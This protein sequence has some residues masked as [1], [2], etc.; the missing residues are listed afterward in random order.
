M[1]KTH[2]KRGFVNGRLWLSAGLCSAAIALAISAL[3]PAS[4][5]EAKG[6][7]ANKQQ[8]ITFVRS[9]HHDVSAPLSEMAKWTGVKDKDEYEG[10]LNPKLPVHHIDKKDT[11]VQS[12]FWLKTLAPTIPSTILNFDGI[13]YPGVGCNCLPPDTN[14][15]IGATQ[16]VQMVNEGFQV[17]NKSTGASQL[18]PN[19]ISSLWAGFGG[20]CQNGGSGDPVVLYDHLA[21]RWVITQFATATGGTPIT[22]ECLAVST[23]SDATGTYTRYGFHLGPNFYD[24]PHLSVWPDAY[25]MSMN[26]FN[27]SGTAF[28]G[29][30]AFAFDRAAMVAGTASSFVTPGI[31]GGASEDSFL[32][33]DLD[34]SILPPAGTPN[35]FVEFP[36]SG[37]YKIYHFHADFATPG[38]TTFTLFANPPAAPFTMLCPTTRAC[39]TQPGTTAKLDGIGDRLMFRVGY[40][41]F[42]DGHES[43][44]GNFSVSAN[45]VAAVRWFELRNV[46]SGPVTVFQE[47]TFQPDTTQRWMG[48]IAMDKNGNMA[49]GYS[50]SSGTVFPSVRYTGRL[51]SDPLNTMPQGEADLMTGTGSQTSSSSRWG[52]YSDM[53]VDPSDDETFWFTSEY[54]AATANVAWKTRIGNFTFLPPAPIVITSGGSSIVSAGG[55]GLPDPGETVTVSLGLQN[56]GS[57]GCT[58]ALTGTLQSTGGVTNPSPASQNYGVLCNGGPVVFRNFTFTVDPNLTC[59]SPITAS[60]D[61][62]DGATSYGTV[63]YTFTTGTPN[64]TPLENFDGVTAPALPP[65]WVATNASGAAPLWVTSTTTPDTAPNDAFVDDPASV[66]DKR[67][68]TPGIAISSASAKL[69][70]RNNYATES[71]YDGGVLEVSSPNINGGAFTD[72]T[73]PAVG[74]SITSGGYTATISSSFMNPLAG[75]QAWSGSSGGYINTVVNLGPN[76]NGQTVKFRFRMGSDS[77]V[78]ATGWRIDTLTIQNGFSCDAAGLQLVSAVSRLNHTGVGTFDVNMPLTGPTGSE[79]RVASTYNIVLTFNAT[80]TSG[81]ATVTSGT[82]TAGAPTFSGSTMT[83]PLTGVTDHE[84]V[85]LTVTGVNGTSTSTNVPLGFLVGDVNNNHITNGSDVSQTKAISGATANASNFRSDVNL[86]GVI[87]ASDVS[88]IK[89]KSGN[90]IP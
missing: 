2:Q 42:S 48:S 79:P 85:V 20:A 36:G 23:T 57:G 18:G 58:T 64:I 41:K 45:S 59:G 37:V 49:L 12:G 17:F 25:Y 56:V 81:T 3:L 52:D 21:N 26:V 39:I 53:T 33:S 69:M 32:P 30:Q 61:V 87:N 60:L 54:Y 40:R 19:S 62:N 55:N 38:N 1:K 46:S 75:R 82:G 22:D 73:D 13:P 88:T 28:L 71:T 78:A 89:S 47:S 50:A 24:Y 5:A 27:S 4:S 77:S 84:V 10:N 72:V 76:L 34:G 15:V 83:V 9:Y 74:G 35:S 90:A 11:V 66:S 67:L 80:V 86:S 31:T 29:P 8:K 14:G 70:F 7:T 43:V 6:K 51:V 44:V 16:Y 68:D 63:T 65:G